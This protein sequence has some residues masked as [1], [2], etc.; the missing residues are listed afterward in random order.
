MEKTER[1]RGRTLIVD[2][3]IP[4][5]HIWAPRDGREH[6]VRVTD[7]KDGVVTYVDLIDGDVL[8]RS[9]EQF[10]AI[11]GRVSLDF[12]LFFDKVSLNSESGY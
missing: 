6:L 3:E 2:G 1:V 5:G 10:S 11:Y 9:T 12:S 8:T 4:V 7:V